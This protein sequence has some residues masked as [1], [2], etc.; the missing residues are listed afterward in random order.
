MNG[1]EQTTLN[2]LNRK[3]DEHIKDVT[4]IIKAFHDQR[5]IDKFKV[6][7]WR[8]IVAVLSLLALIGGLWAIFFKE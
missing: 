7:V 3:F 2:E 6:Q 5:V 8:G 1:E 4:P